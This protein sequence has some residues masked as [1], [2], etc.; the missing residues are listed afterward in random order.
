MSMPVERAD[1]PR[2]ARSRQRWGAPSSRTEEVHNAST[3][4]SEETRRASRARRRR[5]H[6][7]SARADGARSSARAAAPSGRPPQQLQHARRTARAARSRSISAR[8]R[9]ARR[10]GAASRRRRPHR[11]HHPGWRGEG[12]RL[13][14]RARARY[15]VERTSGA[16][17]SFS[18][19]AHGR[20]VRRS[21]RV[22]LRPSGPARM[23]EGKVP[24]KSRPSGRPPGTSHI[25]SPSGTVRGCH[26][27]ADAETTECNTCARHMM[28]DGPEH[29]E[30][31]GRSSSS[32]DSAQSACCAATFR[33][34]SRR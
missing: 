11:I 4:A 18:E 31:L 17:S 28:L 2:D 14:G 33:N 19:T 24:A 1:Q 34:I 25:K 27:G 12:R 29:R 16:S 8:V 5:A 22:E 30:R 6:T 15:T 23:V 10:A 9:Q 13:H 32:S 7:R 20:V 21:A 26:L 3:G